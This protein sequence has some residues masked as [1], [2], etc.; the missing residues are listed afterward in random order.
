MSYQVLITDHVFADLEIEERILAPIG[1]E[2][3]Q[4]K[5]DYALVRRY[6]PTAD[7]ILTTFLALDGDLVRSLER[8]KVIARYGIGVDNIDLGAARARRIV[9]TNVPD[10]C[11]EEV[12]SHALALLLA[13]LRKV[14]QGDR[15][16]RRGGWGIA[17][18]RPVRRFSDLTVGL[19]GVGRI[20]GTLARMLHG[21]GFRVVAYDP[22]APDLDGV[23]SVSFDELLARSDAVSLHSPLTP[24][25]R[26][27]M[28]TPQFAAM[29]PDAVLVN[30][31]RGGL[32]RLDDLAHALTDGV[33]AGAGLDVFETEPLDPSTL[34]DVPNLVM[35]PHVAYYSETA[36]RESAT[37]ASTQVVKVLT[38]QQPD[39][40]VAAP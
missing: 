17:E 25:T 8:C 36:M 11:V 15:V 1:G 32:V 28:G 14:P 21:C 12:A 37:K 29:K 31:S 30:T 35:T 22:Y 7:A 34:A 40:P 19:V 38:G 27:L 26:G 24:Q 16:V 9:V 10:Y 3:V 4:A 13:L 2:L 23:E 33:I 18:L 20:G 39:Y 5:G 6:A